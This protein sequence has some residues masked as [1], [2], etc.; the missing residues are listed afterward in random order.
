MCGHAL[1]FPQRGTF[2]AQQLDS[3]HVQRYLSEGKDHFFILGVFK[4]NLTDGPILDNSLPTIGLN[5]F[6]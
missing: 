2:E 5:Y 1:F 6:L 4:F 3:I